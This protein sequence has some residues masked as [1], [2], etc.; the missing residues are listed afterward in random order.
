MYEIWDNGGKPFKVKIDDKVIKIFKM[1]NE[2]ET[3]YSLAEITNYREVF[4]GKDPDDSEFDG[5]SILVNVKYNEY[6]F[7]GSSIFSFEPLSKIIKFVS[8]M[9]N[10]GVPYPYAEDVTGNIYLLIENVIIKNNPNIKNYKDPYNYYYDKISIT[11][12][13]TR[14]PERNLKTKSFMG[15][16]KFYIGKEQYNMSYEPF[17]E[18]DYDRLIPDWGK[19]MFIVDSEKKK[20]ELTKNAYIEIMER[21][22][23]INGFE[24]MKNIKVL[25]ER[26][27]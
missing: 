16:T 9:G 20:K 22:G 15:I 10:S 25:V 14:R 27:F 17:P 6:I 4:I 2:N 8:V 5:N 18:K 7:I 23:E 21:F 26:D 24:P 13:I 1:N 11:S 12:R 3:Y 19:K